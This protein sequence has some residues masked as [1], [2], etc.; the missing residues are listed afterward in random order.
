M[1]LLSWFGRGQREQRADEGGASERDALRDARARLEQL[2]PETSRYLSLFALLLA[3][4]AN[5]DREV[6]E[7][8][9]RQMECVVQAF[10]QIPFDQAP[11]VVELATA[12]SR[13]FTD[14]G[15]HLVAAR[16]FARAASEEQKRGLLCCMFAVSAADASI[17]AE[18]EGVVRRIARELGIADEAY[19][20]IR[21]A[22]QGQ[23]GAVCRLPDVA[24]RH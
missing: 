5:V 7:A 1:S 19:E 12:Q 21:R 15:A 16:E 23:E 17:T 6:N 11:L 8:E 2:D 13:L 14:T 4:V 9:T 24:T 22:Y 3:R 18:E 10:G 20:E